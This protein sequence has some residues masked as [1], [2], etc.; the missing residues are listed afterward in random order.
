LRRRYLPITIVTVLLL[1]LAVAGYVMPREEQ[2]QP[3][4]I[5][6]ENNGGR[7][8]FTHSAHCEDYGVACARC[9]HEGPEYLDENAEP[10]PCGTCHPA[11]FD[12]AFVS[13]HASAFP[14]DT[15]CVK[16][17][18]AEL[19]SLHFD[20]DEHIDYAADDCLACHHD[21]DIDPD[22][23]GCRECHD[24]TGGGGMPSMRE[25][26]HERCATCHEDLFE[27]DIKGCR[28]CHEFKDMT[29]D[30]GSSTPCA[31]CHDTTE[32]GGELVPTRTNAFH[33]LC[34]NCHQELQ[35]G[36]Y[37]ENGCPQCHVR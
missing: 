14:D 37:G 19:R 5:L 29:R 16:C 27:Q 4:R 17:H 11:S 6:F 26:A 33:D 34:M 32:P 20:H 35:K 8:I 21:T 25:A 36:P 22:T 24:Q 28:T 9:H 18:H 30:E 12:S 2:K 7:V 31:Q 23:T 13:G 10:L 1:C 15:S 3:V